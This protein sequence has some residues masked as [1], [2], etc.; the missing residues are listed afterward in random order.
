MDVWLERDAWQ[1]ERRR[2]KVEED[3]SPVAAP[4]T[5]V[6]RLAVFPGSLSL[7]GRPRGYFRDEFMEMRKVSGKGSASRQLALFP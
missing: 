1:K 6:L 4:G 3:R 2:F 5:K 7:W